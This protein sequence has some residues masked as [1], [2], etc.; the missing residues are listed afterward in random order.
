M[1]ANIRMQAERARQPR[2]A[3]KVRR[4][5]STL[6]E[7]YGTPRPGGAESVLDCLI[8][9]IL[10]Q[11]TTD[12]TSSRAW[13]SLKGRYRDWPSAAVA[14]AESIEEAIR[15]GGLA[16]SKSRRIKAILQ[17]LGRRKVKYSL[18][19]LR[20]KSDEDAFRYLTGM[21]G[22]G[23]KTA[24]VVLL[25]ALGRDI[26]PV[27]THID[28]LCRRLGLAGEAATAEDVFEIMKPLVPPGAA[29]RLHLN[30]IRFAKE[31]CRK[32]KPLCGECP[33]ARQ[34]LYVT[35]RAGA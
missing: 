10:S 32:R 5:L 35:V 33:L 4:I 20:R 11:N 29:H 2:M 6:E 16:R 21:D 34:C 27:D 19:F 26:L 25:F 7:L 24:A 23:P 8:R 22:V 1:A 9:C 28:R 12:L 3:A 14:P 30:M 17:Q 18:E 13:L 15:E 31:R